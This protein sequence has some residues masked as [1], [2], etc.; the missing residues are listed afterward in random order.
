MDMI[1]FHALL[2]SFWIVLMVGVFV[3]I[4]AWAYW[5]RRKSVLQAHAAIP[6]R[7]QD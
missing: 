7:D 3:S 4:V 6:F 2:K 5:P 1:A